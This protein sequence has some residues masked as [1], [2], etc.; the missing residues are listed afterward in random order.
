MVSLDLQRWFLTAAE[1]A[2]AW[3]Q[4][5]WAG[6]RRESGTV[7]R[8]SPS[9]PS[10]SSG[11]PPSSPG[12][13]HSPRQCLAASLTLEII[14]II[15]TLYLFTICL[16]LWPW[17]LSVSP[18]QALLSSLR[19]I[20]RYLGLSGQKGSRTHCR[21][22]GTKVKPRRRGHREAFPMMD[23]SPKIC[24]ETSQKL[25]Q[26]QKKKISVFNFKTNMMREILLLSGFHDNFNGKIIITVKM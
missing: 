13:P 24:M 11:F 14:G 16:L 20:R 5:S 7:P 17:T 12:Y 3:W 4:Q 18:L 6:D 21:M 9:S 2:A 19:L 10:S 26:K 8:W 22:A 15:G 1:R 23:S 25:T